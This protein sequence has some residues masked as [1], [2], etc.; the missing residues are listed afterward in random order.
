M[1]KSGFKSVA[2]SVSFYHPQESLI[3]VNS[4][5]SQNRTTVIESHEKRKKI[6]L[7]T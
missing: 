5:K 2:Q 7:F 1:N 4:Y 6:L 3:E